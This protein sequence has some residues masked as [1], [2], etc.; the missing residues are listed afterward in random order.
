M[1]NQRDI[2]KT[3]NSILQLA[4]VV[5]FKSDKAVMLHRNNHA[6]IKI[7]AIGRRQKGDW[8]EK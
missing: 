3:S 1:A 6:L 5:S 4:R 7:E 8:E 2:R